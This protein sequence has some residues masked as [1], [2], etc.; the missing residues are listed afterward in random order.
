MKLLLVSSASQRLANCCDCRQRDA[1]LANAQC[2]PARLTPAA[3]R[4]LIGLDEIN[5]PPLRS[6]LRDARPGIRARLVQLA[7]WGAPS[8]SSQGVGRLADESERG[9]RA[10]RSIDR[11]SGAEIIGQRARRPASGLGPIVIHKLTRPTV[12]RENIEN[13]LTIGPFPVRRPAG[14]RRGRKWPGPKP[15][16]RSRVHVDA[17]RPPLRVDATGGG[18]HFRLRR[19]PGQVARIGRAKMRLEPDW[20]RPKQ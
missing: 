11:T 5:R 17:Q 6:N 4:A 8:S 15:E 14:A 20:R 7:A 13:Q 9:A 1:M 2:W 12:R 3:P 19:P 10:R 18:A 16:A